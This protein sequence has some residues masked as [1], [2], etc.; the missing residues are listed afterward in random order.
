MSLLHTLAWS[1]YPTELDRYPRLQYLFENEPELCSDRN[2]INQANPSKSLLKALYYLL[3]TIDCSIEESKTI[4]HENGIELQFSSASSSDSY[5]AQYF[6][7]G[8]NDTAYLC[9]ECPGHSGKN[10]CYHSCMTIVVAMLLYAPECA[11]SQA[12]AKLVSMFRKTGTLDDDEVLRQLIRTHD[13]LYFDMLHDTIPVVNGLMIEDSVRSSHINNISFEIM[14]LIDNVLGN[15]VEIELSTE[16]F[17][18][19]MEQ[20]SDLIISGFL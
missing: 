11:F 2:T 5:I 15:I 18:D 3:P 12:Y 8:V 17:N 20:L 13:E 9:H 16:E 4:Y 19:S 7:S 14:S 10:L 6:F 1:K